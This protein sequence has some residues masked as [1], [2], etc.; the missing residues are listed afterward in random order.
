MIFGIDDHDDD[1]GGGE[2]VDLVGTPG[3]PRASVGQVVCDGLIEDYP[4]RIS[5]AALNRFLC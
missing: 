1:D 5:P 4:A 2:Y 3:S